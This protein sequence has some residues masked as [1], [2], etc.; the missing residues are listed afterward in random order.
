MTR[1]TFYLIITFGLATIF[2]FTLYSIFFHVNG[3]AKW[4]SNLKNWFAIS[5][6]I[7]EALDAKKTHQKII[8]WLLP[9]TIIG[10]LFSIMHWPFGLLMFLG[11]LLIILTVLFISATKSETNR[12]DNIMIL[13][14]PISRFIFMTTKIFHLPAFWWTF[15]LFIMGLLATY[16]AV[17]LAKRKLDVH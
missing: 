6:I 8:F 17:R 13:L 2:L 1:K 9:L 16:L 7:F 15:D 12:T 3:G 14:F 11:S 5:I 10:L 4:T